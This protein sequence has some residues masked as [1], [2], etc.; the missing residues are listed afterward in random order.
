MTVIRRKVLRF[1][2]FNRKYLGDSNWG[3]SWSDHADLIQGC[4]HLDT[5]RFRIW[6]LSTGKCKLL[7]IAV[8]VEIS[9]N[10]CAVCS[11]HL[12]ISRN[13]LLW[14]NKRNKFLFGSIDSIYI[15]K[16]SCRH[17][18]ILFSQ[19]FL[20]KEYFGCFEF[21]INNIF[22]LIL[23]V[24]WSDDQCEK[25][26]IS[27]FAAEAH[28]LMGGSYRL[29]HSIK[30]TRIWTFRNMYFTY[31]RAVTVTSPSAVFS[32]VSSTHSSSMPGGI[33]SFAQ[34]PVCGER[35]IWWDYIR[36]WIRIGIALDIK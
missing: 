25:I 23:C 16:K 15:K 28:A 34:L 33:S 18:F 10:E 2:V 5:W 27:K 32:H 35:Q 21:C 36:K 17:L 4:F 11:S 1:L 19:F 8:P 22:R 9:V 30:F 6:K 7:N 3:V 13:Q 14:V 31:G 29:L 12:I 20:T 26:L 24:F